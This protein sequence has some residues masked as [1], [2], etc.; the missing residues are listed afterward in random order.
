MERLHVT[1]N[2]TSEIKNLI[3]PEAT[4]DAGFAMT[5]S[6]STMVL[7]ALAALG[8]IDARTTMMQMSNVA[9]DILANQ[10]LN[11]F[12]RPERA[13][14]LGCGAMNVAARE[15]ALKVLE[16]TAGKTLTLWD[17]SLG[18][19]HGPKSAVTRNTQVFVLL[20]P[21]PHT[22]QYDLDIAIELRQQFTDI[23]VTT[24]GFGGDI[25]FYVDGD[26]ALSALLCVLPAQVIAARWSAELGLPVDDPFQG[27]A[28]S[29]V[30]S[31]VRMYELP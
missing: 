14:F 1:C 13:V 23:T 31:G 25:P 20:H 12:P 9:E 8:R 29:R 21:D 3:L 26:P 30:V 2:P 18:F 5:S 11:E 16:L 6:F 15:A 24:I 22:R 7:S 10:I 19:R 27:H 28:L 17:S 4:H